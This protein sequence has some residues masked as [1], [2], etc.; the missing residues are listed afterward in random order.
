[1]RLRMSRSWRRAAR[2]VALA[3]FVL[4]G[5]VAVAK[6]LPGNAP[7][8]DPPPRPDAVVVVYREL[9][10]EIGGGERGPTLTIYG[11]GRTVTRWPIFMKRAGEYER[12]LAPGELDQLLRSLATKGVLD[13]DAPTVR[14]AAR[15]SA[16]SARARALTTRQPIALFEAT[17]ASTTVIEVTVD[18]Y[19]PTTAGAREVRNLEKRV[20]WTGLRGDA[21][22][23]P[24]VP[25]LAN[26]AAAEQELRA[27]REHPGFTR[28][29]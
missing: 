27:L 2:L 21:A 3:V 22:A 9:H 23:H 8:V 4:W 13:F 1:M 19:V 17:D 7:I 15:A 6:P 20:A 14:T 26:L 12:R 5:A 25:A 29:R 11:D 28:V 10:G 24:D 16:T 18:R